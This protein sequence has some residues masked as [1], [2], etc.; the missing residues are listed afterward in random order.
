MTVMPSAANTSTEP[1]EVN[2]ANHFV[3]QP[4]DAFESRNPTFR[5]EGD[6]GGH[7]ATAFAC[8]RCPKCGHEFNPRNLRRLGARLHGERPPIYTLPLP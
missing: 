5:V 3:H 7:A 8:F 1:A 4:N 6:V 2:P